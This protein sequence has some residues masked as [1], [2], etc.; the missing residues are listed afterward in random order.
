MRPRTA[1][2][3]SV[4]VVF[5]VVLVACAPGVPAAPPTGLA[6]LAPMVDKFLAED[7]GRVANVRAVLVQVG[8]DLVVERRLRGAPDTAGDVYS[9][10]KS[11][12]ATLVGAAIADGKISG[13]DARLGDLLPDDAAAMT[14]AQRGTTLRQLLTM[15]AGLSPFVEPPS[16]VQTPPGVDWLDAAF[17]SAS[18]R[19]GAGFIYSDADAHVL[20]AVLSTVVGRPLLDYA[21]EKLFDPLGIPTAG[22]EQPPAANAQFSGTT[23]G[24]AVDPQ[25]RNTGYAHLA[26]TADDLLRLGRLWLDRGVHDGRQLVP[27]A[28]ID[29]MTTTQI[30]TTEPGLSYGYL[31]WIPQAGGHHAFAAMGAGGQLVE[32]V[33]DLRLVA[34][35]TSSGDTG[36]APD[37]YAALI[38]DT[39][40]PALTAH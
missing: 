21:R 32:V 22:A 13:V 37:T 29:A 30:T 38:G 12:V 31:T 1:T 5:F 27:A 23:R 18:L 15:N 28:W 4:L 9:V 2:L 11:V 8:G 19:P 35:V 26:L 24:W 34:V 40:I 33:P 39:L 25:G 6:A 17:A 16:G 10:T 7:P 36:T 20:A 14:P 3:L